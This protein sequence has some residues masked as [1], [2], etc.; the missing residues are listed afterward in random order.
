MLIVLLV[1]VV[2][3]VGAAAG[4]SSENAVQLQKDLDAN[5]KEMGDII[6]TVFFIKYN[7]IVIKNT[8]AD[9][10]AYLLLNRN[11][12]LSVFPKTLVQDESL[13]ITFA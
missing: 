4:E 9:V 3:L 5:F 6:E 1:A 2:A 13:S 8:A 11:Y 10:H 12:T 7:I